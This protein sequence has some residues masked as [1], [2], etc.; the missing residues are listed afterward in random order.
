MSRTRPT[1]TVGELLARRR[2]LGV[3][4]VVLS[5]RARGVTGLGPLLLRAAADP[6]KERK[7]GRAREG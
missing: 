7:N 6:G 2:D 4:A 1:P 3:S 5:A